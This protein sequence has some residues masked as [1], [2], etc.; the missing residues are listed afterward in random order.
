MMGHILSFILDQTVK[1]KQ[2]TFLESDNLKL[3]SMVYTGENVLVEMINVI[4]NV[5]VYQNI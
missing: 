4:K 1:Y 5:K 3:S 2:T